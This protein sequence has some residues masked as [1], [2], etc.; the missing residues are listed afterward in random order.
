[1]TRIST[2]ILNPMEASM[3]FKFAC[4]LW[5]KKNKRKGNNNL[6]NKEQYEKTKAIQN[7]RN[8]QL[9]DPFM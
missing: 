8:W 5:G 3:N 2:F 9:A 4:C 6:G 1:M 7:Y